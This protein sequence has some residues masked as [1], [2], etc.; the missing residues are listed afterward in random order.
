MPNISMVPDD[1]KN[2]P[3][4]E[5]V[6]ARRILQGACA[7][8]TDRNALGLNTPLDHK[9]LNDQIIDLTSTLA[10][11]YLDLPVIP[12][13]REVSE[14]WVSSLSRA[15]LDGRFNW[16]AVTLATCVMRGVTYKLNGQHTC[17]L[18][19]QLPARPDPRVRLTC[20]Q[21][22]YLFD[23]KSLYET[24]DVGKGRTD[25]QLIDV[26]MAGIPCVKGLR[27]ETINA[28]VAAIRYRK[29]CEVYGATSLSRFIHMHHESL[30]RQTGQFLESLTRQGFMLIRRRPILAAILNDFASFGYDT[31]KFW[32]EVAEPTE[33]A[34][35]TVQRQLRLDLIGPRSRDEEIYQTCVTALNNWRDG[36]S[37]GSVRSAQRT[38]PV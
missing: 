31:K 29:A 5:R 23:L 37:L 33:L 38:P 36:R 35:D 2:S 20:Y 10:A 13:A 24:F 34:R 27:T 7:V 17:Q 16:S 32:R 12:G 25:A 22:E 11:G 18:R 4:S 30:F 28:L 1:A 26:A 9:V 6:M 21:V 8:R 19:L 3:S 15:A 14:P